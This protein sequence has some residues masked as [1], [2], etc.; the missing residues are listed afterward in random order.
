MSLKAVHVLFVVAAVALC[1]G[2][3]VL[4][5]QN[6]R[7]QGGDALLAFSVGCWLVGGGLAIYGRRVVRK[8]RQI[9]YF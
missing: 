5:F 7:Q 8:L 1:L 4:C 3:G 2:V 6:Y 9:S